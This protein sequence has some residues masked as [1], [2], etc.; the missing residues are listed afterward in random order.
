M[1]NGQNVIIIAMIATAVVLSTLLAASLFTAKDAIADASVR[2]MYRPP[3]YIMV[4]TPWNAANRDAIYV[5]DTHSRKMNVYWVDAN[6]APS[7][8][9][10][11]IKMGA[12]SGLNMDN[13]FGVT[14]P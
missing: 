4:S 5:I 11:D 3:Q 13:M 9:F 7:G 12:V 2:G 8:P 14:T 1:K 10:P 6:T